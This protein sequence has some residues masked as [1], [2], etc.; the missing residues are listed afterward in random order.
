M[1]YPNNGWGDFF[2]KESK[3]D[4]FIKLLNVLE[5]EYANKE[6]YP[7]KDRI[8]RS[9]NVTDFENVKVV[10]LGQ[11][12]YHGEGEA[13]GLAFST[14]KK[15][16]P[17]SLKNIYKELYND[18]EITKKDGD[19]LSWAEQGILL[20]NTVL[21]VEK[22]SPLS[23]RNI[24]WEIF[25]NNLIEYLSQNKESIIFVLWGKKAQEKTFLI[26]E[27]KHTIMKSAHPSPFSYNRGFKDSRPFSKINKIL[28]SKIEW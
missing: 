18:L 25:T 12:P 28:K 15:T 21:T 16:L 7:S 19:L 26:N 20:I 27:K 5:K 8:F 10:I 24:G 14:D 9:F 22:D 6:I 4:Y 3:K 2:Q 13:N 23:H 1:N 11:D 17:P